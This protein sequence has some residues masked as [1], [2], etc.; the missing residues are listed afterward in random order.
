MPTPPDITESEWAIMEVLWNRAPQTAAEISKARRRST[1][2]AQNTVRTLL[3]RLVEKGALRAKDN[4][5]GVREFSPAVE[6]E[7]CVR[8][9]SES[10]LQRVFQG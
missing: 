1:G 5:A 8:A 4:T 7:V 6:R 3:S 2:W 10:F 9:E